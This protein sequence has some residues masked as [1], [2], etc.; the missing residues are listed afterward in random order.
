MKVVVQ[1]GHVARTSG[2][3][4]TAGEQS[5]NLA[6]SRMLVRELRA[7]HVNAMRIDADPPF[8]SYKC[9]VFVAIHADG[10]TSKAA[11]G[12]SVGYRDPR[13]KTLARK[14]KTSYRRRALAAGYTI[15][16]RD[17]NYTEALHKYYG[18]GNALANN[19]ACRAVIVEGGFLTNDKERLFLTSGEGQQA[20]ALAIVD[21]ITGDNPPSGA[22]VDLKGLIVAFATR[23]PGASEDV[24]EVQRALNAE[25][26]LHLRTDGVVDDATVAAY[27]AH[28][29]RLFGVGPD[30]DGI[31]GR[32]SLE[33]LGLLVT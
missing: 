1:S 15:K 23:D 25:Y 30:A 6:V 11:K 33:A 10:S 7:R 13:G 12:A 17:D 5:F 9:D 24:R 29:E 3:T 26:E 16:F 22:K 19:P 32:E 20:L 21:A 4:G 27:Q 2:A 31:P 18:T 14:I 28:Q 8:G